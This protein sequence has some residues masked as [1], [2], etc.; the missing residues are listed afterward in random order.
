MPLE[1]GRSVRIGR[2]EEKGMCTL[3]STGALRSPVANTEHPIRSFGPTIR[4][5][6]PLSGS[7]GTILSVVLAAA[8]SQF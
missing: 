7:H 2:P 3:Q 4:H 5:K 8:N 1:V 6:L